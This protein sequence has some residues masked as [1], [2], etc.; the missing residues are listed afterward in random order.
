M[1]RCRD[2]AMFQCRDLANSLNR[3]ARLTFRI[4]QMPLAAAV[5]FSLLLF[6]STPGTTVPE[7]QPSVKASAASLTISG[8]DQATAFVTIENPT[9]YDVYIIGAQSDAA[10]AVDLRDARKGTPQIV[11]DVA[12]PAFGQLE[13]S[14]ASV[15]LV[16]K[17][18]KK[19]LAAGDEVEIV[20]ETDGGDRLK[21]AARA[22]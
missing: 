12:V 8:T 16:L 18:L 9:M 3:L 15:H 5:A 11:K 17:G 7:H 2:V 4:N 13:M 14:A 19:P 21:V 22:K 10:A 6:S 20:L 1:S